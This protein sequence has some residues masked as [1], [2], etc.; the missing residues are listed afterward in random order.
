MSELSAIEG[1]G[2]DCGSKQAPSKAL[3]IIYVD[4]GSYLRIIPHYMP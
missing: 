2:E 1:E 4:M 3:E